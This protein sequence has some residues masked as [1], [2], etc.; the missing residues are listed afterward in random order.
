MTSHREAFFAGDGNG[1]TGEPTS[2]DDDITGWFDRVAEKAG[3]VQTETLRR[4]IEINRGT[5]YLRRWLG[6]DLRREDLELGEL[7]TVYSSLVPLASPEDFEPYLQRIVDGDT[8][9]ILTRD[10]IAAMSL[11]SGTTD[12]RPKYVPFTRFMAQSTLQVFKLGAAHRARIFPIRAGG[13]ILEFIYRSERYQTRGGVTVA[14]ATTHFYASEE[15][16]IKER[17]TKSFT[18][19]P[20]E[21]I[22]AG[23]YKQTTYCHLLLGL[24]HCD[25]VEFVTSAFAYSIV[26]AFAALEELW[27][28]ICHDIQTG[29]LSKVKVTSPNVRKAVLE[30]VSP[31][32]ALAR[33]IESTCKKLQAVDWQGVVPALWPNA[34]YIYS[35]M[36]GSMLPYMKKLGHYAG[37]LPLVGADYGS[38]E[39]WIGVNLEPSNPPERVTFTVIPTLAYFEFIPL[40]RHPQQH[41]NQV[42]W[43]EGSGAVDPGVADDFVEE[44]PVPLSK[45]KVGQEYELVLTTFTGLYRYKLGDVVEVR[46]FYKGV[47][48]TVNVDRSTEKDLQLAVEN[49]SRLLA[50]ARSELIDFTSHAIVGDGAQKRGHYVVYWEVKGEADEDV[51]QE[52]CRVM[53]LAFTECGYVE[54]RRNGS[55][56]PLELR[57]VETGTFKKIL[58]YFVGIGGTLGQFKTPRCTSNQVLLRILDR[59]TRR[60]F[61]STAYAP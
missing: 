26:Q 24:V 6:E 33:R 20:R 36:T 59:G 56:G 49:A 31:D 11:S 3:F 28:E 50:R 25:H 17:T 34:K 42:G 39:S 8:S 38:S 37:S 21:M 58:D 12:G 19:S 30:V 9:S 47:F 43:T 60:Q 29:G 13:R 61:W 51:L 40:R 32:P 14:A 15:F 44:E 57:V 52:C 45:V 54:L 41:A 1:R 2:Q 23:D 48:L 53:D 22:L 27:P 55:I 7:E 35:I 46:G 4:I 10:T 18:C 5:E 16:K